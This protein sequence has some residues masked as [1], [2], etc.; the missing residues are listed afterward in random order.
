VTALAVSPQPGDH[1][2]RPECGETNDVLGL[3]CDREPRHV[4]VHMQ[5]DD[6]DK[7][8]GT[9]PEIWRMR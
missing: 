2:T 3:R 7:V 1:H 9:A 4:G 8:W 5:D 6:T